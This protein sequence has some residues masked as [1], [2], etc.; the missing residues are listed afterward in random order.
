M[1]FG[2]IIGAILLVLAGYA[3]YWFF[4]ASQVDAEIRRWIADKQ[5]AGYDIEYSELRVSGFPYRFE[6]HMIDPRIQAP[7]SDGGWFAQL[8]GV[9]ANALPYDFS[10]WVVSFDGPLVVEGESMLRLDASDARFSRKSNSDGEIIRVGAEVSNL[11]IEAITGDQPSIS[12]VDSLL[13]SG[14]VGEDNVMRVQGQALG[15]HAAQERIDPGIALAFG[16]TGETAR[17]AMEVTQWREL[18]LGGDAARWSRAGGEVRI[19]DAEFDWGPAHL[20]GEGQIRLNDMA[21]PDGRLSVRIVNPDALAD[22][23]IESGMID[24]DDAPA[25]QMVVIMAPRGEEGVS[26]PFSINGRGVYLG[27]VRVISFEN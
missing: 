27:P 7:A 16:D 1:R 15:L 12:S 14:Q 25:L 22:A 8:D 11:T 2:L 13:I 9:Q 3:G 24:E 23:L 6:I 19:Q 26:L 10:L 21:E 18:A 4:A 20:S 5:S 17:L